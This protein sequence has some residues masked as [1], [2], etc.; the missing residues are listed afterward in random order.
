MDRNELLNYLQEKRNATAG[1][2][3]AQANLSSAK[4]S[5]SNA[6]DKWHKTILWVGG[7]GICAMI[8]DILNNSLND[9]W[10]ALFLLAIAA[11]LKYWKQVNYVKPAE[12]VVAQKR[13]ELNAEYDAHTYKQGMNGFPK[14]FYNYA[15]VYRLWN[16]VNENRATTLQD[17]FN[18]LETQQ[19]QESQMEIQKQIRAA[20]EDI[21]RN[22]RIAAEAAGAAAAAASRPR[23]VEVS[24]TVR[25][26]GHVTSDSPRIIVKK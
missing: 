23:K 13:Q 11:G 2:A 12:G 6:E 21:A 14:K 24:G 20:Q 1:V 8:F 25:H 19:F 17:A 22:A 4:R 5:L 26:T 3:N 16:L 15:D 18:L 10:G 9:I 7:F